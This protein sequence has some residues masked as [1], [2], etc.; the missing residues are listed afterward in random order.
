M[1][2]GSDIPNVKMVIV[3]SHELGIGQAANRAAVL[4]TGLT[5][6][7]PNVI[8]QDSMTKDDRKILG[9]TQVPIPILVARQ[10]VSLNKLA[11]KSE[12]KNCT[13]LVFLSRAQGMRSYQEY[14]E[15][16]KGTVYQDLD[17]DAVAIAGETKAVTKLTG[18]L[19]SLR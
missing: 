2:E 18:N 13:T 19:P 1:K 6:H 8:G 10:D 14:V 7:V 15:S 17:I 11:E 5:A 16:I 3:V 12:Q 4:A 9:F